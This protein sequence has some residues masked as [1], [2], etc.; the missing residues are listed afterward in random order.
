M[1]VLGEGRRRE[2][3]V[4]AQTRVGVPAAGLAE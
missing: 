1:P 2:R 3:V 4:R